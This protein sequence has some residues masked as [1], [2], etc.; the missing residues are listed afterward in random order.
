M[1]SPL[2]NQGR[3]RLALV[4]LGSNLGRREAHLRAGLRRLERAGVAVVEAVSS[5]YANAP[6]DCAGGEFLNGAARLRVRGGVRELL[7]AIH[8][9]ERAAGRRGSGHDPRRLDI[10]VLYYD[11]RRVAR[12]GLQIPHPRRFERP[13][14]VVPLAEVC[15]DAL[16][17]ETG[18]PVR[19][20]LAARL[21]GAR[22][23][24]RRAAGPEWLEGVT[25]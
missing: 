4:A 3:A 10:D 22:A 12:P 25:R 19:D 16:D 2:S 20:E 5:L 15:G 21:A 7:R 24:V 14:V 1:A 18:R 8:A 11:N 17:P 23:G 6:V 9:A 13:F